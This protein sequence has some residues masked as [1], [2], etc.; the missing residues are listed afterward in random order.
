[1]YKS[2][3]VCICLALTFSFFISYG[4]EHDEKDVT[5]NCCPHG[6]RQNEESGENEDD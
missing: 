1:M 4:L 6:I 3:L 2:A 5:H